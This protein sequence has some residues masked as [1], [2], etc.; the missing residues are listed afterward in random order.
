VGVLTVDL[1]AFGV[2]MSAD[3]NPIELLDGETR[4]GAHPG[5]WH[6]RNPILTREAGGFSGMIGFVGTEEISTRSTR[7]WLTAFDARHPDESL[8][9]YADALAE[10]LTD[11]WDRL[12]LRSVLEIMIAGV[13]HGEIRFWV[14][15]NSDGL[16][17][18]GTYRAPKASFEAVDDLDG[19]YVPQDAA[20]GQSKEDLLNTRL[21]SFRLGALLPA[22]GI[23]DAFRD[24]LQTLFANRIE[25][26]APMKSLGDLGH[27]ARHRLEFV[28]RLY[29]KK[30]GIYREAAAPIGGK[31]HVVGVGRDGVIRKFSKHT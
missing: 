15:R 21:Y 7:D 17:E 1:T 29:S 18:D 19:N 6:T 27:F 26:F 2:V 23:F 9:D 28:K 11:E 24:I 4:L 16:N 12:G 30:H 8:A 22:A 5:R 31:I 3:S 10:E 20:P 14:V 13:E 25:G